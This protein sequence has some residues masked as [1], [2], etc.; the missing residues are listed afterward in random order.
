METKAKN[1]TQLAYEYILSRIENGVYG[2]GYRVVIDQIARELG[3]SIIP[4]REAIRQLEAEG[5]VEFKPYTGA[6]VSNINE[7]EYIETL[8][9]LAVLEGYATALGSANLTKEAINEL[10]RLNERMERALEELEL[11]RF[12]ELNY[13]FHSLIYA[14]CGNAYLEEQIKQIWQRMKRIR[15]YGFTFVPQRAK[16]SI[17]E[18][19]EIIRLLREQA[20]PHEIEQ[21][22]RQHK[23]NTAEAFKRRR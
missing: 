18:H 3:L 21:Y 11:E 14:H 9:V 13:E 7:K 17:E 20:P 15:A 23:I 4:V 6:V 16:A 22:V 19:R 2:P 10:E 1:K 8:S 12:S 5:L